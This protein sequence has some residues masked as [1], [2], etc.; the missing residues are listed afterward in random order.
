[1]FFMVVS[2]NLDLVSHI[3]MVFLPPKKVPFLVFCSLSVSL[4]GGGG[5][6]SFQCMVLEEERCVC[7]GR[8]VY[9]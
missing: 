7:Y 2:R 6:R 4:A 9:V 1:M 5:L 8:G 3:L